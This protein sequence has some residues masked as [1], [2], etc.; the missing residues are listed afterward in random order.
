MFK[1]SENRQYFIKEGEP[2]FLLADTAWLLLFKL[3]LREIE[4][5]FRNRRE[6]GFNTILVVLSHT[7]GEFEQWR[8]EKY[9]NIHDEVFWEKVDAM[10]DLSEKYNLELGLLPT[11]GSV[12][13]EGILTLEN[14]EDYIHFIGQRYQKRQNI[15][16]VLGGDIRGEA[17]VELYQKEADILKK[18]NSERLMTFH[19]FG[20]TSSS[21]WFH[22]ATW[23][24]FNMFQSGHRR[25]DQVKL[26]EWDDASSEDVFYGEDSWK[27]VQNDLSLNEKKPVLD[28]EPSY[29]GIPQGLHNPHNLYWEAWDVRRYGYWSAFAGAAGHTY[30]NNAIM[31]FYHGEE[32]SAY[33]VR[34]VWKEALHHSGSS[35]L[36]YLKKLMLDINY[37]QGHP[38]DELLLFGQKERYHRVAV[39]ATPE[40]VV[41]YTYLG[42]E[43][44]LDMKTY[45]HQEVEGYWMNP[46][47]GTYSYIDTFIGQ[48]KILF[49]PT[50]RQGVGNDWVLVLR[51][52]K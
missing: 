41:C 2:F 27:Y 20:R 1:L 35:Q 43:F 36:Q 6:K 33:G 38:R 28:G 51:K 8:Q 25:Y 46:E 48:E 26:G 30:G 49:S 17:Y 32:K 44:M 45:M 4:V 14:M 21:Q 23:L 47:D 24:D 13:K 11:W 37:I 16:W 39:F 34:E 19:P 52:T 50:R 40:Y 10:I 31:Q 7:I 12:V 29:E 5:Y 3:E 18:Y 42:N 9:P 15:F 22:T